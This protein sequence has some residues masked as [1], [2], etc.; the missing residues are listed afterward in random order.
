MTSSLNQKTNNMN[1]SYLCAEKMLFN[2][3]KASAKKQTRKIWAKN[4]KRQTV[5]RAVN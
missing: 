4:E 3:L 2:I 5:K 1:D